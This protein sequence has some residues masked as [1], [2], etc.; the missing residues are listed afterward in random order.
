[1]YISLSILFIFS[2]FCVSI[3]ARCWPCWW[4]Y[5]VSESQQ[6]IR[7]SDT[8]MCPIGSLAGSWAI[9]YRSPPPQAGPDRPAD[10]MAPSGVKYAKIFQPWWD[11]TSPLHGLRAALHLLYL[12]SSSLRNSYQLTSLAVRASSYQSSSLT[13]LLY[14]LLA[15]IWSIL[16]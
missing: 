2:S 7:C 9:K 16:F 8:N 6:P 11:P 3:S 10:K 12:S 14:R 5:C 4:S 13:C 15:L 1:M